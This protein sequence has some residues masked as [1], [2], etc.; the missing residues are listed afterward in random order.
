MA[1][2]AK[3]IHTVTEEQ[4]SSKD[5][6][7][8]E[9][10]GGPKVGLV[11]SESVGRTAVSVSVGGMVGGDEEPRVGLG[12]SVDADVDSGTYDIKRV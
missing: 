1:Q 4:N 7:V 10:V 9:S 2:A 12:V 11:G 3:Q 8:E 5:M 6:L